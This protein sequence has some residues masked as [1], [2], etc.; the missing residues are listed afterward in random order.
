MFGVYEC[1]H[2]MFLG[3]P[4][5]IGDNDRTC[6]IE[7]HSPL[8]SPPVGTRNEVRWGDVTDLSGP[9]VGRQP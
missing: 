7:Y 6:L 8:T 9:A 3:V 4:D 1:D 2:V 5:E